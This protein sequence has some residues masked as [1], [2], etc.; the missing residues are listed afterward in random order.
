M[1]R[2]VFGR[3]GSGMTERIL[4]DIRSLVEADTAPV[5]LIVP[6]QQVYSAERDILS[7]LPPDAGKYFSIISFSRLCDLLAD[8]YGGRTQ[9]ALSR[10][11]RTLFMW[12]N[13]REL[14]GLP[15]IYT[16][17][18]GDET[19]CRG[20]LRAAEEFKRNAVSPARLEAVAEHLEAGSPLRAK[21]RDLALISA[22]YD[23]LVTEVCG[24]NP[25]DRLV[26][27]AEQID[28]HEFFAGAHVFIDSFTSF[29]AQEYAI[30]RPIIEQ[31]AGVTVT[32]GCADRHDREPQ[33]ETVTDT[34]RRISRLCEDAGRD[35]E[36]ICLTV[37]H[38]SVTPEIA[39]LEKGLWHYDLTADTVAI[40]AEELRGHVRLTVAPTLYDEAEAVALHILEVHDAGVPYGEI[41]VTV[42]DTST[43]AGVLDAAL[44]R[45]RIP[46]FLSERTDL[47][48]KPAARLLLSALGCIARRYQ[49]EDVMTLAKTGL[50]GVTPRD[51]DYFSEYIETWHL[52][53]RRMTDTAWSMNPDGY[54][55]DLTPRG[56][57]ILLAANRV[58]EAV[59]TPLMAL[60]RDL[61]AAETVTDECRAL[62]AY[63][64]AVGVK[65]QLRTAAEEH[66]R[67]GQVREAGEAIRLWSF[68]CETLATV[69]SVMESAEPLS[70]GEMSTALSLVFSETD[71]G[72]VPARHDCVTVGS[73]DTLRVDNIRVM[74]MP[75]LC[76]GEFPQAVKDDGLLS[77]RD[78]E[79]LGDLGVELDSRAD[80]RLS[81][82]LLYVWRA[83]SKPTDALY[84]SYSTATPDGQTRTPSAVIGRITTLLPYLK[85]DAFSSKLL[86]DGDTDTRHRTPILD[87]VSPATARRLFGEEAF[88]S[89][90]RLQT[91]ARCPYSYYGAYLLHLREPV[92]AKLDNLGAGLFLHHVMEQYLRRALDEENRIRPM[93]PAEV[94]TLA[95]EIMMAYITELC[96]DAARNGRLLHLFDRLRQVALVLIDSIQTELSRSDFRVAGLEWNTAG[97]RPGDPLPMVLNL[98]SDRLGAL[99]E[100]MPLSDPAYAARVMEANYP[101]NR[102]PTA[103]SGE[104]GLP[105]ASPVQN[106]TP[107]G[108][109]GLP[110]LTPPEH[111][112][113]RLILGGR[114]DRVDLYRAPDGETVYIRVID[115]KSS[116]HEFTVKSMTED[117]NIQLM[118]YLFTLCSPE[119][120]ALFADADGHIPRRVLPAA[121]VYISPDESGR[122]GTIRPLRTG[123]ALSEPEIVSAV[124][125]DDAALPY[126]PSVKRDKSGSLTGRGLVSPAEMA[127][128]QSIL[129]STIRETAATMYAG[130]A[131]RTPSDAACKYCR[132]RSSC[133]VGS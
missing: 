99:D 31:A 132:M 124:G 32:F 76:E 37:A 52:T 13:L 101:E 39:L 33:F 131:T 67:L 71:I 18:S 16:T 103:E 3:P 120:R 21:L 110:I 46:F 80:R 108:V 57:A 113:I 93:E 50:C 117:M 133:G 28:A 41:A 98:E 85:P 12:Q 70:A 78:K 104:H 102:T 25:S 91:Y 17:A 61:K 60:E 42:R 51:V 95:D 97:R 77:E 96:G 29:T 44:E 69:A 9:H 26:R 30:L 14:N 86:E 114:V 22:A 115:Y 48:E 20:M 109:Q 129:T 15:E 88:L 56:R 116:K 119:N 128:L 62:Y 19:L 111:S 121:A 23:G 10:A 127:D 90:S 63:L 87:T 112:P 122:D 105:T 68:L 47:N 49:A 5:W 100:P 11:M 106:M 82:E 6:E 27:A 59:M 43:W 73:A 4:C 35:C 54:T 36:D 1:I 2:F 53:G 125:E 38:V 81:E 79:I 65:E 92:E 84:L 45:Y 74:L 118:L 24:Q 34:A 107:D 66:L 55:T 40:P 7:A 94:R 8:R 123:I 126:L 58:R 64:T 75:G 83:V 72:S 130:C 89:Q